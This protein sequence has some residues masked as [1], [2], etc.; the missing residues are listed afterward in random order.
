MDEYANMLRV[1]Q[2]YNFKKWNILSIQV[3][4]NP[5]AVVSANTYAKQIEYLKKFY[6]ER[7]EYVRSDF[8]I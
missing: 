7:L 3:G 6:V 4:K 1:A 5:A 2:S 8:G